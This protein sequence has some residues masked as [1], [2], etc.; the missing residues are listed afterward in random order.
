M[1]SPM[2]TKLRNILRKISCCDICVLRFIGERDHKKVFEPSSIAEAT[3]Q[4]QNCPAC[5]GILHKLSIEDICK[6]A[7]DLFKEQKY[8]TDCKT[9]SLQ[10]QFPLQLQIRQKSISLFILNELGTNT[11]D[12][13]LE[14]AIEVKEIF[15]NLVKEEFGNQSGFSFDSKS[16]LVVKMKLSHEET[17]LDWKFLTEIRAADLTVTEKRK[18]GNTVYNGLSIDKISCCLK[19][20]DYEHFKD[21]NWCPPPTLFTSP[22]VSDLEIEHNPIFIAGRYLKLERNISNSPWFINGKRITEHSVEE[23]IEKPVGE[24]FQSKCIYFN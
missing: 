11:D 24:F 18:R 9:F 21:M 8:I 4:K 1:P 12:A 7:N 22:T 2:H 5:L 14:N 13:I 15:K 17:E 16:E 23:F 19:K 3:S 10:I 6:T 20:L